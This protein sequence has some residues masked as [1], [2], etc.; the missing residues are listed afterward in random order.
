M[1]GNNGQG[2][3]DQYW[4][5]PIAPSAGGPD[6]PFLGSLGFNG[7][8]F[9]DLKGDGQ[10]KPDQYFTKDMSVQRSSLTPL[11][12]D[13]NWVDTWPEATDIPARDL[14]QGSLFSTHMGFEMGRITIGRHIS[15]GP[16]K[17]SRNLPPGQRLPGTIDVG[18][19]DGHAEK[20]Q[21]DN[22]WSLSWHRN[23]VPPLIRPP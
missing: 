19:A 13:E 22:L 20:F 9:S 14:Y 2:S 10:G 11:F 21:M 5:K 7:W 6:V 3:A 15:G 8:F 18:F 1:N 17:A 12:F 23:Y 4:V 16:P